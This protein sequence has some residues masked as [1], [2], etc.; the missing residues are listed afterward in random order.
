MP[1]AGL[2][3]EQV[4]GEYSLRL[5]VVETQLYLFDSTRARMTYEAHVRACDL[6]PNFPEYKTPTLSYEAHPNDLKFG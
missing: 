3:T 6:F 1:P 5:P 4:L 2:S